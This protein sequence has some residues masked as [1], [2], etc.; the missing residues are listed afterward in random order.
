MPPQLLERSRARVFEERAAVVERRWNELMLAALALFAWTVGLAF[1][2]VAR[3]LTGG[4]LV[5]MGTNLV[6]LGTWSVV[7]TVMVWLTAAVAALALGRRR[8][9]LRRAS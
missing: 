1:W 7:S 6:R 4:A 9:A 8:H 5:I 2:F 3:V